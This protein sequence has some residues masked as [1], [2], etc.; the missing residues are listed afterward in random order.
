MAVVQEPNDAYCPD[1]PR[2]ALEFVQV[3]HC[4]KLADMGAL[5][6]RLVSEPLNKPEPPVP[7]ARLNTE[8]EAVMKVKNVHEDP[9]DVGSPS[10]FSCPDCGGVLFEMDDH[11][12]LR[13]RCRVGHGFTAKALSVTQQTALDGALWAALRALEESASLAR[14]MARR[15]QERNHLHSARRYE[16]RAHS[17]EQQAELVRQLVLSMSARPPP[18][19]LP[20]E[21]GGKTLEEEPSDA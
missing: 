9:H 2:S 12:L 21:V 20:E 16:E 7:S 13:Y 6:V 3:D 15:A 17:T 1:M 4:V 18:E 19:E 8:V 11:G 14:R 10:F 5:L